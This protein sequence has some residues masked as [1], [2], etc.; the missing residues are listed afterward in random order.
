VVDTRI[1]AVFAFAPVAVL[2]QPLA[3]ERHPVGLLLFVSLAEDRT[4][5]GIDDVVWTTTF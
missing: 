4:G 2:L 5:H 1:E 3:Q